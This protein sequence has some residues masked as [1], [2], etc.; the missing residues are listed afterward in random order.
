VIFAA[1][2]RRLARAAQDA[3]A[4]TPPTMTMWDGE[5][6]GED[7]LFMVYCL[8]KIELGVS[9]VSDREIK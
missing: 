1:S 2:E 7:V 8:E 5:V 6:E 4:A 3:P 9:V